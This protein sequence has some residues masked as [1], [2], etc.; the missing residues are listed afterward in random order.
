MLTVTYTPDSSSSSLYHSATGSNSVTVTTT[1]GKVTPAVLV[2]PS[3]SSITTAQALTVT[4][5]VG[6]GSGNGTPS[7]S[8]TLTSG[9]YSSQQKL[10]AGSTMFSLAAGALPAGTNTLNA[11]YTPDSSG[12]SAYTTATQ[13][14]SVTVTQAIGEAAATVTVKASSA[15]IT[16]LDTVQ[17][18]ISVSGASGQA[19]PTG[20]VSLSSGSYSAQQ[21][22]SS[23][24]ASFTIAAGSLSSGADTLTAAYSG[25]A[26]YAT[27]NATTNVTVAPL[28]MSMT[29]LSSI[30]GGSSGSGNVSLR[31]GSTYSGTIG[32]ACSLIASP[33]GAQSLPTCSLNPASVNLAA[34]GSGTAVL[35][36]NTSAASSAS[37]RPNFWPVGGGVRCWQ[38]CS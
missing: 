15:A 38:L 31:A 30:S 4:V 18:T 19:T 35:T 32:I 13:S 21:A 2:T 22:L 37:T 26:T 16:D 25:D 17:V 34:G 11:T 28:V 7:G 5:T 12:A 27:A 10:A 24:M 33:A 23:G 6:G 3:A 36:V 9:S 1:P 14:A 8:V 29:S 20:T